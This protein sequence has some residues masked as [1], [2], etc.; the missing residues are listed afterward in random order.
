MKK[1]NSQP[2]KSSGDFDPPVREPATRNMH[3]KSATPRQRP[4]T[5]VV[6]QKHSRYVSGFSQASPHHL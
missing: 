3:E 6:K 2:K 5:Y 1:P 4:T